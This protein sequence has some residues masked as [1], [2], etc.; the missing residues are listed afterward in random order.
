MTRTPIPLRKPTVTSPLRES[1][2]FGD[3]PAYIPA[4]RR[5]RVGQ[6][7]KRDGVE[8]LARIVGSDK[9]RDIK[10]SSN[11][12]PGQFYIWND[13]ENGG[14]K[15]YWGGYQDV[16]DDDL[17]HEFVVRRGGPKGPVIAVNGYT[18]KQS[19]WAARREF[20]ET[21]PKRADRKGKTVKS[22]MIDDYYVPH[23]DGMVIDG[24]GIQP[25]STDDTFKDQEWNRYRKYTPKNSSPYQAINKYIVLP[26]LDMYLKG[27]NMSRKKYLETYGGVGALSRLASEIYYS[28]VKA[29]VLGALGK[30]DSLEKLERAFLA[31]KGEEYLEDPNYSVEL[32]KYIFSRKG[33]KDVVMTYVRDQVLPNADK[34]IASYATMIEGNHLKDP[35]P[36]PSPQEGAEDM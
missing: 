4:T 12:M 32:E 13:A 35:T 5:Q 29:P 1:D 19:D 9:F 33:I 16:D 8:E 30:G 18:T 2:D 26:A 10:R 6:L 22:F 28:L 14:N 31:L 20:F 24:W 11:F 7:R 17:P 25:G 15:K 21:Y 23:Y 3:M 27:L 36:V 34:L